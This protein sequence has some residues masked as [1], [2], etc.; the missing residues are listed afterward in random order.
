M[1]SVIFLEL[2]GAV[3]SLGMEQLMQYR[4]G[5]LGL[6]CLF[7]LGIGLKARNTTCMSVGALIFVLLMTQV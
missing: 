3:V 5:A 2:L 1:G 4:D 6:L 7:L